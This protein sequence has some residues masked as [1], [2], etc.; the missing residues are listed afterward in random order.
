MTITSASHSTAS[1]DSH[2]D[3]PLAY[4]VRFDDICPTMNWDRW[5][6][7]ERLLV[8]FD[9]KPILS[10]VPDNRDPN[11]ACAPAHA[12]FWSQVRL[13]QARG[14]A[15]G[16][17]GYTHVYNSRHSGLMH[18]TPQSEFVGLPFEDQRSR[19]HRGMEIFRNNGVLPDCWVAPAHS[20]DRNTL[21]ALASLGLMTVSDG[22][23]RWPYRDQEG[24][25]WVPQ[26]L[27]TR[28]KPRKRGI[29]T[30]C[31]HHNKWNDTQAHHFAA[32][33][34]EYAALCTSLEAVRQQYISRPHSCLDRLQARLDH[35]L[36]HGRTLALL[37]KLN[38]S[39]RSFR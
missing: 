38:R 30:V 37:G 7:V 28:F 25:F 6:A 14:W 20:F 16:L 26:Q 2:I 18:L 3:R 39:V 29:W 32:D 22:L 1:V 24:M 27:W 31:Y 9:I 34:A 8:K 19:L 21:A 4:L 5:D 36:H 12:D 13:W 15:I 23:S 35:F 33:V 17:H 11:L 10:V